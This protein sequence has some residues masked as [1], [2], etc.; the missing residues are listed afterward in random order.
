MVGPTVGLL[1][2]QGDFAMH[3]DSLRRL[4]LEPRQVRTPEQIDQI[5]RLILPGGESSTMLRLMEDTGIEEAIHRLYH[6]GG[7]LFG[8]CAGLI[9]LAKRVSSPAQRSLGML[10]VDVV[11][12]AYGRQQ[13]S[14]E[15][16][17]VWREDTNPLRAVHIRAPKVTRV[18]EGVEVLSR[19]NGEPIAVRQGRI[20]AAA[21]H[22]EMTDDTRVHEY[23]L[24]LQPEISC[25]V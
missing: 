10:D 12:N 16:D 14:F 3:A 24:T 6:R 11:R 20:L 8:T 21:F 23:F 5:Q 22:P 15:M 13:E 17:V 4:D 1:A 19:F 25:A 2:L 18:G 9:L 7:C